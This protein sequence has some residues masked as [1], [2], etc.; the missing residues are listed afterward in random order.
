RR[1]FMRAIA[2]GL[3]FGQAAGA[4][5]IGAGVHLLNERRFLRDIGFVHNL[6]LELLGRE[7]FG[8]PPDPHTGKC[9]LRSHFLKMFLMSLMPFLSSFMFVVPIAPAPI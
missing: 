5:P 6:V 8:K 7:A 2:K 3:G 1:A 9:A 4:P